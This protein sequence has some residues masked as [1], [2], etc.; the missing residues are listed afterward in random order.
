MCTDNKVRTYRYYGLFLAQ[1]LSRGVR[2]V[3]LG[4]DILSG[5]QRNLIYFFIKKCTACQIPNIS[6]ARLATYVV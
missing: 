6:R 5:E 1:N 2:K 3:Q 4:K